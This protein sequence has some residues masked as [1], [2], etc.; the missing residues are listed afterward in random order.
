MRQ[1]SLVRRLPSF[2]ASFFYVS[3]VPPP[4]LLD[5]TIMEEVVRLE[6]PIRFLGGRQ[7]E[8]CQQFGR[9]DFPYITYSYVGN[10]SILGPMDSAGKPWS[11][12]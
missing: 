8:L 3:V 1:P 11:P 10:P 12:F 4:L 6:R 7:E 9:A 5:G 2:A